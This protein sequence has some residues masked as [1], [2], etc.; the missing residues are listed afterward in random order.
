[1]TAFLFRI[2]I[3][4]SMSDIL[5]SG[6]CVAITVL[7]PPLLARPR[8]AWYEA[9]E[10][11]YCLGDPKRPRFQPGGHEV[12]GQFPVS[13]RMP[14]FELPKNHGRLRSRGGT[15]PTIA[16]TAPDL[17]DF[18]DGAFRSINIQESMGLI[19]CSSDYTPGR[20]EQGSTVSRARS[21]WSHIRR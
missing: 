14:F 10:V 17:Y 8:P 7:A 6:V 9:W 3:L 16:G 5:T 13:P 21:L 11:P 20:G 1:M 19:S 15:P 12:S 4:L 2:S 18:A